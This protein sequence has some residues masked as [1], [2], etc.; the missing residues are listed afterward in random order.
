MYLLI[1]YVFQPKVQARNNVEL[2]VWTLLYHLTK[3]TLS[4]THTQCKWGCKQ[5]KPCQGKTIWEGPGGSMRRA[6]KV[7][8]YCR[9]SRGEQFEKH[10]ACLVSIRLD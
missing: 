6:L 8:D 3:A 2:G 1:S 10:R 4:S 7:G 5:G 9:R